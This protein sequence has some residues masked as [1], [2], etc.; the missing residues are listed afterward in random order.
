ME[1]YEKYRPDF[2]VN[3]VHGV[4]GRDFARFSFVHDKKTLYKDYLK[5]V[6]ESLDAPYPYD[7]VGHIGYIARYVP[8]EDKNF[9]LDTFGADVDE[10]LLTIIKKG[11][12]LEVNSANKQLPNRTL[13]CVGRKTDFLWFG[14]TFDRTYCR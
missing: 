6:R 10:V 13:F 4:E 7:I 8:F 2:V 5:L 9:D 12:I 3:S 11:K 1:T 14:C